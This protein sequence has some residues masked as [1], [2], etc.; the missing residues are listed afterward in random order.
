MKP[1]I[2]HSFPTSLTDLGNS[3]NCDDSPPQNWLAERVFQI[4]LLQVIPERILKSS[5]CSLQPERSELWRCQCCD[6]YHNR[7]CDFS[8]RDCG[9]QSKNCNLRGVNRGVTGLLFRSVFQCKS[10][11]R[12]RSPDGTFHFR[13]RFGHGNR[14]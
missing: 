8:G 11:G 13:E 14:L 2:C 9:L 10:R 12:N 5:V 3:N 7:N 6:T 4:G 1:G